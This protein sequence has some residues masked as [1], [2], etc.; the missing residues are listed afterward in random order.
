[1]AQIAQASL[2]KASVISAMGSL[3]IDSKSSC[4]ITQA[5]LIRVDV[6]LSSMTLAGFPTW[7]SLLM[8]LGP[9]SA[10][11]F[12]GRPRPPP[13][14]TV[15]F[16]LLWQSVAE[17]ALSWELGHLGSLPSAAPPRLGSRPEWAS[18]SPYVH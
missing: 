18:V 3:L 4:G 9:A 13:L 14:P 16:W 15:P 17:G 8:G 7:P 1:M 12:S 11:A 6:P 10:L 5:R 2:W